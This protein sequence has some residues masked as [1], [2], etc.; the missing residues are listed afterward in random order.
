MSLPKPTDGLGPWQLFLC[1]ACGLIYDEGEGDPDS[2]L[3]PGTRFA[4]IPD[5]WACPICGVTKSD[6]EPYQRR[7]PV[8]PVP[9]SLVPQRRPGVVIVGGGIGGWSVAEAIR[10]ED[11]AVPITLV[12]ACDGSLYHKPELSV[13]L[14]RGLTPD[15][16]RRETGAAAAARLSLRLM[17]DTVAVGLSPERHA[18]RTTRGTLPYTHLVLA[19]G[20]RPALPDCLDP[21]LCW[22][23]N[24]LAGWSSLHAELARGPRTVAVIGA[25]MVGC[26]LA[27]DLAR[28][29]HAVTLLGAK[30]L[31]LPEL[32]PEQAGR[33]LLA[34]LE[35]VGVRYR[36]ASLVSGLSR[37]PDGTVA[38]ALSDVTSLA[39][40]TVIAATGLATPSRLVLGAGLAFDR[41]IV[42]D[43]AT[44]R[45][46][47]P[48][49]FALG[50]CISIAG[51][52]CRFIEPIARQAAVIAHAIL[53]RAHPDY[54]HAAP[55][56]R[57]KTRSAPIALHGT[58]VADRPWHVVEES[59]HRLAM[60]QRQGG[61]VTAWLAA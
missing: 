47:G 13:A 4:D 15:A 58:P 14:G 55:V 34:G 3:P 26:E 39:A 53:G 8:A 46:S 56:I 36:G 21:A 44:L 37:R 29:G 11:A 27:E 9:A 20:A 51:R 24:D 31:P 41:G 25:G 18:L 5:D 40:A 48:D 54:A 12:S 16:L 17:A 2:G 1:R 19:H 42:V 10:A 38:L 35:G 59:E 61:D 50:D 23:V 57:L 22:R 49:I 6:F 7:A 32:L 43:P 28:A 52:P 30:A 33:R 45:T 60:E